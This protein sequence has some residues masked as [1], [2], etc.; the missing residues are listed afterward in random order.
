M[1]ADGLVSAA[2]ESAN[3]TRREPEAGACQSLILYTDSAVL[4]GAER[5]AG[6]LLSAL[7]PGIEV[8]VMGVDPAVV[9]GLAEHRPGAGIEIVP[10]VRHKWH[11]SAIAAHIQAVR[12][13]KPD[14]LQASLHS[15]W[16]C[17]YGLLAG[18]LS[19]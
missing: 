17:Q 7:D 11:L 10:R 5:A 16:A 9:S 1:L 13:M 8:T 6:Y 19:P 2:P 18:M 15:P 4:G 3:A 12:R 14:V